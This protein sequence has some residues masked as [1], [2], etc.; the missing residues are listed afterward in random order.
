MAFQAGSG[1]SVSAA[2]GCL[3]E[4]IPRG[5]YLGDA[6]R[7]PLLPGAPVYPV[8]S[9]IGNRGPEHFPVRR[10]PALPGDQEN[11]RAATGVDAR[12]RPRPGRYA[13]GG[14][15]VREADWRAPP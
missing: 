2:R 4:E 5:L 8:A 1:T 7:Q 9:G 15:G 13:A 11:G 3:Q 14:E 6:V 10:L 12:S